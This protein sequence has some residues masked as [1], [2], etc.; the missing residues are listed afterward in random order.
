MRALLAAAALFARVTVLQPTDGHAKDFEAGY[1]RHLEWH[2]EHAD[3]WFWHGWTVVTGARSGTFIDATVGRTGEELDAPVAPA[4]DGAD[5]ARNVKPF[6]RLVSSSLYRHRPDLCRVAPE[7]V[8]APYA[9]LLSLEGVPGKTRT[10]EDALK[11]LELRGTCLELVSGGGA[12]GYLVLV[13]GARLSDL[14]ALSPPSLEGAAS[15]SVEALLY[16]PELSGG[17]PRR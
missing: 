1:A 3:P 5:F 12:P 11:R 13:P 16:K 7:D 4:E 14:L 9:A 6:A 8:T 15:I 10:L 17:P 2:G